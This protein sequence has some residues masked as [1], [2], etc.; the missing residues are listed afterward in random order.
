MCQPLQTELAQADYAEKN[1]TCVSVGIAAVPL[2]ACF[3]VHKEKIDLH[4]KH[5]VTSCFEK[6]REDWRNIKITLKP[7]KIKGRLT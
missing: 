4:C 6:V 3:S 5:F 1:S 7:D 2:S